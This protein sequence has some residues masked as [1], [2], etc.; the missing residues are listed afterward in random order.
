MSHF[1]ELRGERDNNYASLLLVCSPRAQ[2]LI[3]LLDICQKEAR[4]LKL[5]ISLKKSMVISPSHNAWILQ[6]SESKVYGCFDKICSY[7][8]LG[9][10]THNTMYKT[11]T[12]KQLKTVM[13]AKSYRG[14]CRYLSRRGPD[15]VEVSICSWT[16]VA[17]PALLFGS[18]SVVFTEGTIEKLEREQARWAKETLRLP[19]YCSNL[20]GQ[21]LLGVPSVRQLLYLHQLKFYM[22]LNSLPESR[23]AAQALREHESGGW[24]SPYLKNIHSIQLKIDML[25]RPSSNRMLEEVME[26]YG[27]EVLRVKVEGVSSL[28]TVARTMGGQRARSA[29]EGEGWCWIN[30]AIMG[31]SGVRRTVRTAEWDRRCTSDG[32]PNTDL[33]CVVNCSRTRRV[34]RDTGVSMFFTSCLAKG[35]SEE[36]AYTNYIGG[37]DWKGNEI[38][39]FDYQE[40]GVTLGNIFKTARNNGV[41]RYKF[42]R[43]KFRE[44]RGYTSHDIHVFVLVSPY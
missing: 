43:N 37:L 31:A 23:F 25:Q 33:H 5:T 39:L 21:L 9:I 20:A 2:G 16:N 17:I 30:R 27:E 26:Q 12:A 13:A 18:E 35:L 22:R 8:Y 10:D 11:S 36:E 38:S 15:V 6:D 40:R 34:R 41:G 24:V 4:K 1:S 14:A 28:S 7:K 29:R 32:V 44:W 3:N 42:I 19:Q